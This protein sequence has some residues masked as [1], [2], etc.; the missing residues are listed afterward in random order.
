MTESE[1]AYIAGLF[2]GEGSIVIAVTKPSTKRKT[3]SPSHWLQVGITNT[4]RPL[5]DWLHSIAGGHVCDNSH[6][7]SRKRQRPCFAWRKN[8]NQAM[9]FLRDIRPYLRAKAE[10]ADIAITF[11]SERAGH[12][13]TGI[14]AVQVDRREYLRTQLRRLTLGSHSLGRAG[15]S[16]VNEG[17]LSPC[18]A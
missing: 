17:A 3:K 13:A 16:G 11:Q 7:P 14:D 12:V 2:D 5:I 15:L 6:S 18:V 10:Q 9:E 8:S 1:K 4:D